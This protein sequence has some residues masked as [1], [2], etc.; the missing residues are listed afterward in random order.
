MVNLSEKKN[1]FILVNP[2]INKRVKNMV[3]NIGM[4]LSHPL[5]YIILRLKNLHIK[6]YY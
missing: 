6:Y 5:V 4:E 1:R 3:Q 2:P